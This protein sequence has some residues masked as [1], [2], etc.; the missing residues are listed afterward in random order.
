MNEPLQLAFGLQQWFELF[1]HYLTLSLLSIGGAI[2]TA[3]DM[4]RFLVEQQHWLTEAQFNAS[5]AIAQA[6]PGPNV[7]FVALLG[8]NIGLNAGGMLSGLLGVAVTMLGIL[9]P[10]TLVTYATSQWGHRNR[11]LR[12]VRAFKQGMAPIVVALLISTGW[13]LAAANG[14]S[15]KDWP[16]CLLT[17]VT[18]L[19]VWRTKIHLLWLLGAGALLGWMGFI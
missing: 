5:I 10:S 16:V 19:I 15:L 9:L 18:A 17:A 3:P 2:T 11:G 13:I 6:A 12:A 7:L 4:H 8:W 14:S 1:T